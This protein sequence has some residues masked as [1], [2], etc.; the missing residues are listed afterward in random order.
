MA[1]RCPSDDRIQRPIVVVSWPLMSR[2]S[3]TLMRRISALH[4]VNQRLLD[5]MGCI[6]TSTRGLVS[7]TSDGVVSAS[8]EKC[9]QR[10]LEVVDISA[11]SDGARIS[12]PDGVVSA[13]SDESYQAL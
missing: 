6:T 12:A 9:Y 2:I 10:T 3:A 11:T 4:G 5:R 8:S 13:P 1:Y 7:A